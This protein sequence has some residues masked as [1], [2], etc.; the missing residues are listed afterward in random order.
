MRLRGV[1]GKSGHYQAL[2]WTL[3]GGLTRNKLI[4]SG[5]G[6]E[7]TGIV[8]QYSSLATTLGALAFFGLWNVAA[9]DFRA[10]ADAEVR[11]LSSGVVTIVLAASVVSALITLVAAAPLLELSG[12]SRYSFYPLALVAMTGFTPMMNLATLTWRATNRPKKASWTF[13]SSNAASIGAMAFAVSGRSIPLAL[14]ASV[15]PIAIPALTFLLSDVIPLLKRRIL[16]LRTRRETYFALLHSVPSAIN[17]LFRPFTD[18]TMRAIMMSSA[19]LAAAGLAQPI[20]L[21][22][23]VLFPA[24]TAIQFNGL[25]AAFNPQTGVTA[26]FNSKARKGL[27]VVSLASVA[28]AA[29]SPVLIHQLFSE[30]FAETTGPFAMMALAELARWSATLIL[31][32]FTN[33]GWWRH[34]LLFTVVGLVSRLVIFQLLFPYIGLYALA[35]ATLCEFVLV[36]MLG[37]W[38]IRKYLQKSTKVLLFSTIVLGSAGSLFIYFVR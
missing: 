31:L 26:D 20:F 27:V 15:L 36:L 14:A 5:L 19:G 28:A 4:A 8:A 12:I 9:R 13:L 37:F 1:V 38:R 2:L 3:I 21:Y 25:A 24:F 29:L 22:S 10:E 17:S 35:F 6:V 16:A 18:V 32:M 30:E 7:A 34:A 11:P 33:V 23:A